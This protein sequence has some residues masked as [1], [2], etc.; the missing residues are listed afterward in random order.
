MRRLLISLFFIGIS[1]NL[2][3]QKKA[4]LVSSESTLLIDTKQQ[5]ENGS[6][7]TGSH[8]AYNIIVNGDITVDSSM[9]I[10][11]S[12]CDGIEIKGVFTTKPGTVF[13]AYSDSKICFESKQNMD[14][15]KKVSKLLAID[16]IGYPKLF[17]NPNSGAFTIMLPKVSDYE[18]RISSI[19]GRIVKQIYSSKNPLVM[20]LQSLSAGVYLVSI[21]D[22]KS[23]GFWNL[24]FIRY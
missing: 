18:I 21:R 2:F 14:S 10:V 6:K 19:D 15:V 16:D 8:S 9:K 13:M 22:L 12:S 5:M 1:Y 7:G 23:S 4:G 17:P 3:A 20:N 24:K 11:L